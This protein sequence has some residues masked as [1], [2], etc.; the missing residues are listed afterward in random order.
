MLEGKM[1]AIPKY[2]INRNIV[3]CKGPPF[4]LGFSLALSINRNIVECKDVTGR[5]TAFYIPY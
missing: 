3:E 2:G 5:Y 4:F 1:A